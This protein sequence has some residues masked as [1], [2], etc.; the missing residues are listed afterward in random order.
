[1]RPVVHRLILLGGA[2]LFIH[3]RYTDPFRYFLVLHAL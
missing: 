2:D 3:E 1:M